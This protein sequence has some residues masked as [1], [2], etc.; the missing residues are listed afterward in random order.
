MSE[1]INEKNRDSRRKF[2]KTAAAAV[3]VAPIVMSMEAKAE[4]ASGG[5][6]QTPPNQ[7]DS[8]CFIIQG[9]I[10]CK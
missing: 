6:G 9:H 1:N 7:Q 3:Y 4:V 8:D 2:I 5:S 10:A